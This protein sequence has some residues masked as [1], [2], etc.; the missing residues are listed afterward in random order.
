MPFACAEDIMPDSRVHP[1]L[2]TRI[3]R[4]WIH[5]VLL[6]GILG[7]CSHPAESLIVREGASHS[8]ESDRR[9]TL[10]EV[11]SEI[12]THAICGTPAA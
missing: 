10:R 11:P 2:P 7:S 8:S 4:R 3:D 5:A 12:L 1:L 9:Q 6:H